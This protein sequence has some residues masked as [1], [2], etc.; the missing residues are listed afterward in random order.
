MVASVLR[1]SLQGAEFIYARLYVFG[2][3]LVVYRCVNGLQYLGLLLYV[4]Q[5]NFSPKFLPF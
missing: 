2:I 5:L 3:S 1:H 4:D